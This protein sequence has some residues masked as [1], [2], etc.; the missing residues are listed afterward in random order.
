MN[1]A[2]QYEENVLRDGSLIYEGK[3]N[4]FGICF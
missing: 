3:N 2:L 1:M 4:T